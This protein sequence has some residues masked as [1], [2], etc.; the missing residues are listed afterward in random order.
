MQF[1]KPRHSTIWTPYVFKQL[2]LTI[3]SQMSLYSKAYYNPIPV[4]VVKFSSLTRADIIQ[5]SSTGE[6]KTKY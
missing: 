4:S 6:D 1:L 5:V 2:I 3:T